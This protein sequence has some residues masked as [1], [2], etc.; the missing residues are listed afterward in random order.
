MNPNQS[1]LFASAEHLNID[2]TLTGNGY[3]P[4]LINVV[5]LGLETLER[6]YL[7]AVACF[8]I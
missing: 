4:Y 2:L 1:R 3:M 5:K 8:M 7:S 6:E